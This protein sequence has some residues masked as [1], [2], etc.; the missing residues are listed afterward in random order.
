MQHD[1]AAQVRS[2][3]VRIGRT[4]SQVRKSKDMKEKVRLMADVQK[5]EAQLARVAAILC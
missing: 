2:L 1:L 4:R 5:L 3:N